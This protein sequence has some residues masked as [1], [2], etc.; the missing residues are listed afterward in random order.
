[1]ALH[2]SRAK[3]FLRMIDFENALFGLPFAYLGMV[4][5]HRSWPGFGVF[6]WVTMAMVSARTAAMCLNRVIDRQIDRANPR[7]ADWVMAKEELPVPFVWLMAILLSV[8]L[9][10][11]A[12]QL[13]PLC[14]R[15]SPLALLILWGYSYTK[16]FTWLCHLIL[17]GA[18]GIG[19]VGGWLAV[20]GTWEWK[21]VL[22]FFVV[23]TW[24]AGFDALYAS[25]DIEFDR[26]MKLHSI[27]AHFGAEKGFVLCHGLHFFTVVFLIVCG[28]VFHLGNFYALAVGISAVILTYEH[29]IVRPDDMSRMGTAAFKLNRYIGMILFIG[30]CLDLWLGA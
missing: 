27:P 19:P 25:Q 3:K 18:I 1:M 7:T 28:G 10:F 14:Y 30:A 24:V 6:F 17:G 23:M 5:A 12:W 9:I 21:P 11:S 4:L 13:N 16:H 2:E 15:L 8:I 29:C 26:R 20:T 22:L